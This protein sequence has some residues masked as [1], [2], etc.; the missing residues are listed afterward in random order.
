ME[1]EVAERI[2]AERAASVEAHAKVIASTEYQAEWKH[3]QGATFHFIEAIHHCFFQTRRAPHIYDAMLMFRLSDDLLQSCL[4][5]LFLVQNGMHNPALREMRYMIENG[6]KQLYVDQQNPKGSLDDK[7]AFLQNEVDRSSINMIG[8]L[9]LEAFNG[10]TK[11]EF[12]DEV[13]DFYY[14]SCAYVHPSRR[15]IDEMV[16]LA[17]TG[18]AMGFETADELR[19]IGRLTFRLY[20][21]LLVLHFHGLGLGLA[22][23]VLVHSFDDAP[24]WKF[25]KGKYMSR[26]SSY[27]DYKA[28]RQRKEN[29]V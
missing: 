25:H 18:K 21:F 12:Y 14:K 28:E 8:D 3:I 17:E 13:T 6:V 24:K 29:N 9:K 23:D 16:N 2:R 27:F 1:A 19:R 7:L 26:L 5:M 10:P 22:G 4:A 11:K 15:Q 20:D